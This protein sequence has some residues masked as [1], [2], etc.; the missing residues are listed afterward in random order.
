[1]SVVRCN[2][3]HFFVVD[4]VVKLVGGGSIINRAYPDYLFRMEGGCFLKQGYITANG[5]KGVFGTIKT[6]SLILSFL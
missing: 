3:S 2:V 1:M 6:I 5:S 4:K